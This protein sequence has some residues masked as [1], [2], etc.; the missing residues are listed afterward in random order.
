[1]RQGQSHEYELTFSVIAADEPSEQTKSKLQSNI[2]VY[3]NR[4]KQSWS[5]EKQKNIA[6]KKRRW[7]EGP[8]LSGATV[9]IGEWKK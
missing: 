9:R 2:C 8:R 1:M 5:E 6:Q 3:L 4:M 7:C